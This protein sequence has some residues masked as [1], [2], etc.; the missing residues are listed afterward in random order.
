MKTLTIFNEAKAI[1]KIKLSDDTLNYLSV[2]DLKK[3]LK[4]VNHFLREETKNI[5]QYLVINN[6]TYISDLSTDNYENALQ[7]F[8]NEGKPKGADQKELHSWIHAVVKC[9]RT[10]EIP[11]FLTKEE[12]DGIMNKTIAPDIIF[13]G[14]DTEEGRNKAA[15][16]YEPMAKKLVR[17]YSAKSNFD[18]SDLLSISHEAMVIAMNTY[19]K[20]TDKSKADDIAIKDYT[21][22]Q[23]LAYRIRNF[24]LDNIKN[25]SRTV[26]IPVSV[27]NK[28]K[29]S[30]GTITKNNSVSGD[31]VVGHDDEGNKSLFDFIGG[32]EDPS[33]KLDREDL[34]RLWKEIFDELE[35]EF[36]EKK[37]EIFYSY[38]GVNGRKKLQNKELAKKYNVVASNITYYITQVKKYIFS[39]K[40]LLDKFE[41]VL[42]LMAECQNDIDRN[43]HEGQPYYISSSENNSVME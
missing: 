12:F 27:Q 8:Y 20:K 31:K 43:D 3:Y 10:K 38:F 40:D 22:G 1:T 2:E 25:D 13:L 6:T 15:E 32:G 7:G 26:R 29:S 33:S 17:Q 21:F 14:L 39:H 41:A 23:Y 11:V 34:E 36:D 5:I 4:T 30:K 42:D 19:G 9:G 18:D 28:E 35:K 37:I 24:I 16:M